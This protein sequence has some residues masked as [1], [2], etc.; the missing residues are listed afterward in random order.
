[1]QTIDLGDDIQIQV[2][3]SGETYVLREPTVSE[4]ELFKEGA[5]TDSVENLDSFL[6]KLGAPVG[7][8]KTMGASKAKTLIEGMMEL[9]TKKK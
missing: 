7:F 6:S 2:K 3:Y 5:D 1:V 4:I 9:I 8:V